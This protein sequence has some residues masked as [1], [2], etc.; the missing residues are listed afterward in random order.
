MRAGGK[1]YF[2]REN[3]EKTLGKIQKC[4]PLKAVVATLEERGNSRS[5]QV[6]TEWSV[7]YSMLTEAG[8]NG[9]PPKREPLK[10]NPFAGVDNLIMEAIVHCHS[11]LSPEN[12][13]CDGE[14]SRASMQRR[15]AELQRKL[16]GLCM[17]LG[18]T[19]TEEQAFEWS[20]SLEEYNR[21]QGEA[22]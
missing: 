19:I 18:R 2:G 11:G 10:Y 16:K 22:S 13:A 4:N 20:A 8:E 15:G 17:A 3:G 1:V 5:S 6:G 14:A 9:G 12:L 7:P 21:K